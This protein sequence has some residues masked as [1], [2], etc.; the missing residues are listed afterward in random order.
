MGTKIAKIIF[1]VLFGVFAIAALIQK[2]FINTILLVLI[3][4]VILIKK[5]T[6]EKFIKINFN[7]KI[8]GAVIGGLIII[9]ALQ[10][11]SVNK[12]QINSSN[13]SPEKKITKEVASNKNENKTTNQPKIEEVKEV[14]IVKKEE[15]VDTVK[16]ILSA[17]DGVVKDGGTIFNSKNKLVWQ[18]SEPPYEVI[19]NTTKKEISDCFAAKQALLKVM[20]DIYGN[21]DIKDKVSRV[22]IT[23]PYLDA[24]FGGNDSNVIK[25]WQEIMPT[26]FWSTILQTK[27]Y[28]DET[29]ELG[30]RTWGVTNTNCK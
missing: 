13:S 25:N 4:A 23:T 8:R 28:K 17:V 14:P 2:E 20:K 29:G 19:V 15:K 5:E 27:S 9:F 24:S 3:I 7:G 21:P 1:A 26:F 12:E 18:D 22:L 10:L 30:N 11:P 16:L 6:V